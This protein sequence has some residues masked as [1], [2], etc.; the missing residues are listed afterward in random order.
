MHDADGK[1]PKIKN[2][3]TRSEYDPAVVYSLGDELSTPFVEHEKLD[4]ARLLHIR[5]FWQRHM[6]NQAEQTFYETFVRLPETVRPQARKTFNDLEANIAICW[7][8]YYC[9]IGSFFFL[10]SL[11]LSLSF[12]FFSLNRETAQADSFHHSMSASHAN[13]T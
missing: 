12:F 2:H 4:L 6:L 10:L 1:T 9:E 8:G 3:C 13:Q 11:S 7:L 5:G